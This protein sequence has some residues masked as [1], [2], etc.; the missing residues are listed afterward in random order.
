MIDRLEEKSVD[1][2]DSDP[3]TFNDFNG[4][5]WRRKNEKRKENSGESD[6]RLLDIFFWIFNLI[7]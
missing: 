3:C 1:L 4:F 7:N 2:P 6:V 5:E